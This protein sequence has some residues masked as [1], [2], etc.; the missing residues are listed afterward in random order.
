M[1]RFY[2][3]RHPSGSAAAETLIEIDDLRALLEPDEDVE[4]C[5]LLAAQRY[6]LLDMIGDAG[7]LLR[8]VERDPYRERL[9]AKDR[10][11]GTGHRHEILEAHG[12][13]LPPGR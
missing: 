7:A 1:T 6:R 3:T 9:L 4:I 13:G 10:L 12:I 8:R 5:S 11:V 2:L